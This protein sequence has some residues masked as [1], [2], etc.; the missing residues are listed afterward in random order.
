MITST[1]E[2]PGKF[3]EINYEIH[4]GTPG[5]MSCRLRC[6]HVVRMTE[7][8]ALLE[9]FENPQS[10]VWVARKHVYG[11]PHRIIALRECHELTVPAWLYM[12]LRLELK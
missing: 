10:Q 1:L 9:R 3:D 6:V 11:L 5:H 4:P 8:G 7:K 12:N 2:A